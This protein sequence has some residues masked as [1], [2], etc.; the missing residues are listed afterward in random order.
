MTEHWIY[1]YWSEWLALDEAIGK[2]QARLLLTQNATDVAYA[3]R[4][5]STAI[6][7]FDSVSQP[8]VQMVRQDVAAARIRV[9]ANELAAT[10]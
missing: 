3:V 8:S 6:S 7:R 1:Q 2:A 10:G 9:S 5:M 4:G